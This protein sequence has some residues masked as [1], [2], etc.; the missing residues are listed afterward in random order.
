[1]GAYELQPIFGFSC[2]VSRVQ[3]APLADGL[4]IVIKK[5]NGKAFLKIPG[6][7]KGILSLA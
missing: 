7:I 6:K 3:T 1:M 5:Q 2:E 4:L